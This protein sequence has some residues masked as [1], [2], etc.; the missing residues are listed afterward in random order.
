[1]RVLIALLACLPAAAAAQRSVVIRN[2][3]V[4]PMT[5]GAPA[6]QPLALFPNRL[7]W[8]TILVGGVDAPLGIFVGVKMY[9][10]LQM[11]GRWLA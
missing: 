7:L 4:I 11:R 10:W 2:V 6:L 9:E 1:L 5:G 3:T 8:L